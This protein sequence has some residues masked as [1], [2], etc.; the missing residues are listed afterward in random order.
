MSEQVLL[1]FMFFLP[2]E[3]SLVPLFG[4]SAVSPAKKHD[5]RHPVGFLQGEDRLLL[6]MTGYSPDFAAQ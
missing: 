5:S 6:L 3:A 1:C 2:A 4:L